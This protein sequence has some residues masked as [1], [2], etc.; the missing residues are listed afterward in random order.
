MKVGDLVIQKA[1]GKLCVII[2]SNGRYVTVLRDGE[3]WGRVWIGSF[4]PV[5][6]ASEGR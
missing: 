5:K 1:N 2:E 6:V 4:K 3:P